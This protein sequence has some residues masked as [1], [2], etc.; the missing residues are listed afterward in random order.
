MPRTP[1]APSSIFRFTA[2]LHARRQA[3]LRHSRTWGAETKWRKERGETVLESKGKYLGQF[4]FPGGHYYRSGD[5]DALGV[6]I[7]P[8][9]GSKRQSLP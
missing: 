6:L 9:R 5:L 8:K 2:T 7:N 4:R 3:W 1:Q